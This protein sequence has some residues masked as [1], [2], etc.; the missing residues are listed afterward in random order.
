LGQPLPVRIAVLLKLM[1]RKGSF[2]SGSLQK[3]RRKERHKF[4]R[5]SKIFSIC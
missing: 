3:I 4:C 5:V 1:I 2:I